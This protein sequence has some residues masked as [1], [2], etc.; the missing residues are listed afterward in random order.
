ML[1]EIARLE[2]A[3][4]HPRTAVW[5]PLLVF[6]LI[7]L[8]GALAAVVVGRDHLGVYFAPMNMLGGLL[9]AWY[10]ERIGRTQGLQAPAFAWLAMILAVTVVA[11]ACSASGR[12]LGWDLLNLAGPFVATAVGLSVLAIWARSTILLA[13]VTGIAVTT[14]VVLSR[15]RGDPAIAL[16]L[17]GIAGTMLLMAAINRWSESKTP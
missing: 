17:V 2:R 5:F 9:C 11:A 7:D 3:G 16:Q 1:V 12:E 8:P 15:A 6:G 14:M 13:V 10:Y 4:R